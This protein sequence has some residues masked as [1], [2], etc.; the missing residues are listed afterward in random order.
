MIKEIATTVA[1]MCHRHC[2]CFSIAMPIESRKCIIRILNQNYADDSKND[3]FI[4]TISIFIK[5]NG[6]ATA[7][8]AEQL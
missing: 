3:K 5:S 6:E 2:R 4:V 8:E 7:P 1:G